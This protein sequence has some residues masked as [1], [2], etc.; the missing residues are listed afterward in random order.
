V[1]ASVEGLAEKVVREL[2]SF[3]ISFSGSFPPRSK[4][5]RG[6]AKDEDGCRALSFLPY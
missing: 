6:K 5:G 3:D 4:D 1:A 2:R